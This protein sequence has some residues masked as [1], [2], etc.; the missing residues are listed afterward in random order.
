MFPELPWWARLLKLAETAALHPAEHAVS[1]VG[2]LVPSM[3]VVL[4][5]LKDAVLQMSSRA[6]KICL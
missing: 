4:G 1:C 3:L 6:R 5:A 2:A